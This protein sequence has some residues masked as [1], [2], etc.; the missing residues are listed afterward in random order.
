[1]PAPVFQGALC[2]YSEAAILG[3]LRCHSRS[4]CDTIWGALRCYSRSYIALLF[5]VPWGQNP[6]QN[7]SSLG[8]FFFPSD[9]NEQYHTPLLSKIWDLS[10]RKKLWDSPF[11][12]HVLHLSPTKL[13]HSRFYI[14]IS[15]DLQSFSCQCL[16]VFACIFSYL[17]M[18]S[19][20]FFHI[21][22]G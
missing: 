17:R 18:I 1:M 13:P 16:P 4:L 15:D 20:V 6:R 21:C 3:P 9:Q 10:D 11:N 22:R 8:G 14:L 12:F 7:F 19:R 2:I 5:E